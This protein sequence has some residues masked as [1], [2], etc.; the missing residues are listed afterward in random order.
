MTLEFIAQMM[1]EGVYSL[2]LIAGLP[3]YRRWDGRFEPL[4]LPETSTEKGGKGE[5]G[6]EKS[7]PAITSHYI[8]SLLL[9]LMSPRSREQFERGEGMAIGSVQ[10]GEKRLWVKL[11]REN[12][13]ACAVISY[14]LDSIPRLA[15]LGYLPKTLKLLQDLT[16]TKRGLVIFAGGMGSGK[17]TLMASMIEEI[18]QTSS[19]R[20]LIMEEL[21]DY[22][23][24][25]AQ[26]LI[27]Q[28]LIGSDV[29]DFA[30]AIQ[31]AYY[32]DPDVLML[33]AIPDFETFLHA[34]SLAESGH[35]VFIPS[36]E[37]T[38]ENVMQ[39]IIE[40]SPEA[41]RRGIRRTL[42]NN[43]VAILTQQLI[44]RNNQPGRVPALDIFIPTPSARKKIREGNYDLYDL[45]E[46]QHVLGDQTKT[47][48]T[49]DQYI[50]E[51]VREG[52][53]AEDVANARRMEPLPA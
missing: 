40:A 50:T 44:P 3:P 10:V 13:N 43:L 1:G 8:E 42:S 35:L 18:N 7:F 26:S 17:M 48:M 4:P 5:K 31:N 37:N 53:I 12:G 41:H 45:K 28:Q 27:T 38:P 49:M 47:P 34:I 2:H 32:S 29:P 20:I 15:N 11:F 23:F 30:T 36:T 9:P 52:L 22:R 39:S 51:L 16:N 19:E 25:H 21:G 14:V 46:D 33:G 6:E 24:T